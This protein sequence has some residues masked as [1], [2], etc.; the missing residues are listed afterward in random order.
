VR[1]LTDALI[2]GPL[3]AGMAFV[4]FGL[5]ALSVLSL[6]LLL[7]DWLAPQALTQ[8]GSW[9]DG[10]GGAMGVARLGVSAFGLLLGWFAL[11]VGVAMLLSVRQMVRTQRSFSDVLALLLALGLGIVFLFISLDLFAV[12]LTGRVLPP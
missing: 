7:V 8:A 2:F 5:A 3:A 1:K 6:P 11:G 4:G 12:M 10:P 9:L